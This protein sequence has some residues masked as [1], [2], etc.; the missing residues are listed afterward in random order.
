MIE[1]NWGGT[2]IEPWMTPDALTFCYVPDHEE[3]DRP[4]ASNSFIYNAM[5]NPLIKFTITGAIWYQGKPN[6]Q[7]SIV[8]NFSLNSKES[9]IQMT[10]LFNQTVNFSTL[11]LELITILNCNHLPSAATVFGHILTFQNRNDLSIATV[12]FGFVISFFFL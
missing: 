8:F 11:K 10:S 1:S 2:R 7:L 6:N 9:N 5:I 3:S 4:E 12:I